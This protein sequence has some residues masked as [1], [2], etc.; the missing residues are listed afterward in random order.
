MV[1]LG[2]EEEILKFPSIWL[3][4]AC[5]RCTE[6]CGE[7]VSGHNIIR[8]LQELALEEG[9]VDKGFPLRWKKAQKA[10]YPIFIEEIDTLLGSHKQ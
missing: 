5:Q 3:C 2:M 10:I 1:N 6:A 8:R 7:L 9:M 4:I